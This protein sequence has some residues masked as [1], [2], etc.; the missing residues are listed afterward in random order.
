MISMIM[1]KKP[2]N[3]HNLAQ[4]AMYWF[5]MKDEHPRKLKVVVLLSHFMRPA[6]SV[7]RWELAFKWAK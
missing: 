7:I 5:N 2:F 1:K 6:I 4:R 3:F